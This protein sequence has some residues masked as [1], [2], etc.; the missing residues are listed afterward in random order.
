MGRADARRAAQGRGGRRRAA[1]QRSG[2]SRFLSWKALLGTFFGCVLLA[3]GGF[4]A[5]YFSVP[6]P[7]NA[8]NEVLE[9]QGNTYRYSNGDVMAKTGKTT[10]ETV[11]LDRVP[12]RVRWAFVAAENKNFYNDPGFDVKGMTYGVFKTVTGQGKSGGSTITQQYVKNYYLTSEQ[13]VS[14]KLKELVISLKVENKYS[15]DEILLGYMNT[16]FYGRRADGVQAA[17]QAYYN[18]DVDELRVEEA[19]Y[20]AALVQA[21]S[22]YDVATASPTGRKLALGRWNMTLDRMVEIGKLDQSERDGMEFP[23]PIK[24]KQDAGMAGQNGY[25]IKAANE[26]LAQQFDVKVA[27]IEKLGGWDVTLNIKKG[28]QQKL[29]KAFDDQL[30]SQLDREDSKDKIVQAGATSVDPK[31]GAI[32]AMYGGV[33]ATEHFTNNAIRTDYQPG[34]TMKPVVLASALENDAKTQDGEPI[35]L[36]TIYDGT[37]GR[38]VENSPTAF[39]PGNFLKKDFG[40]I[41]VQ[42]ATNNSVNSVYAQMIVDVTPKEAKKTALDLGMVDGKDRGFPERPAIVLGTMGASTVEMAGVYAT[43]DNHGEL[44]TPTILKKV[45]H[46]GTERQLKDAIGD[47]VVKRE[48]ADT[49]TKALTGVVKEGSGVNAA[50]PSYE[51]AGK[52]GTSEENV[53]A[54]YAGYTPELTTVV[55]LFGED[56]DKNGAH[57][58]LKGAASS[59]RLNGGA[60]PA[61]VWKQYTRDA[62]SKTENGK[63]DL[64]LKEGSKAPPPSP[65]PTPSETESESPSPEPSKTEEAPQPPP[66]SE[67]EPG[68]DQGQDNGGQDQGQ[69]NGGQDQGQVNGGQDA[70]GLDQGQVNGGQDTGGADTG[71]QDAGGTVGGQDAG[72]TDQ[73]Q[74]DGGAN[75]GQ[76]NGGQDNAGQ[77]NGGAFGAD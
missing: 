22:Q 65:T 28:Q 35:G 52:T 25:L 14:R 39:S 5:L 13:T 17:A 8:S 43:L 15:K 67:P 56:K 75:T 53:S 23:E 46:L 74:A 77:N 27:D 24:P 31:T 59:E 38:P 34:S 70:G 45:V 16:N 18:K 10:R 26:E 49:V 6:L 51:A 72:G 20:L 37:S 62:L 33:G 61:K 1:P 63:F 19:A 55:A 9:L 66:P 4:V 57:V 69:D 7:K 64:D 54:W 32:V 29:E 3:M 12:E 41:T 47:Q 36:N 42:T 44:V 40:D 71:G 30:E 21:P 50:D 11:G 76:N 2:I 60:I 73:G 48:T 58:S 68:Q